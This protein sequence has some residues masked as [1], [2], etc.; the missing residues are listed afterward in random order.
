MPDFSRRQDGQDPVLEEIRMV[1]ERAAEEYRNFRD[2]AFTEL[3]INRKSYLAQIGR[4]ENQCFDDLEKVSLQR[5]QALEEAGLLNVS[6]VDARFGEKREVEKPFDEIAER[7]QSEYER[8]A[9]RLYGKISSEMEDARR[10]TLLQRSR[11]MDRAAEEAEII[12][13]GKTRDD[14]ITI[15]SKVRSAQNR[16]EPVFARTAFEET[17]RFSTE[18]LMRYNPEYQEGKIW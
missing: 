5:D 3:F 12:L 14:L 15:R 1:Y 6:C 9:D 17:G 8:S 11:L 2:D 13:K 4:C 18:E 7:L 16:F 10:Q